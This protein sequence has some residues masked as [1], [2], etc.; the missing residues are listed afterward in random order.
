MSPWLAALA[1][2]VPVLLGGLAGIARLFDVPDRAVDHLN[3]FALYFAFPA[4]VFAGQLDAH[5]ALPRSPGFWILVPVALA[6]GA[7]TGRAL[8]ASEASTLA[9]I[10]AFGNVAYLGLPVVERVLGEDAMPVASLAV[11]IH[12]TLALSVGPFLL[13]RWSGEKA[14]LRESLGRL[15]RQPLLWAPIAGLAARGLPAEGRELLSAVATPIGKSAAPVALFLLGLYLHTHKDRL[16]RLEGADAVHVLFKLVLYPALS[17]GLARAL[18]HFDWLTLPEAQVL[19]L[20]STMPAAITTFAIT[21]QLGVGA[22]RTSRAIVAT[23]VASA[24]TIPLA[25]WLV[26]AWIPTW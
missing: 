8:F 26:L 7:L 18:V 13:L 16:A 9:L 19:C 20:L 11:A 4:L 10:V 12:V 1:L 22:Q 6:I 24:L 2:L 3:R 14:G 5:G 25:A 15:A 21:Q 23:T 17:F